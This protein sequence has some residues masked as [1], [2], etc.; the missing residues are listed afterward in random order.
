MPR[1]AIPT[2]LAALAALALGAL[3]PAGTAS[4]AATTC[5]GKAATIVVPTPAEPITDLTETAPVTGTPGDDVIVGTDARDTI[6]GGAGDDTICALGGDDTVRGGAGDDRLFGGLDGVYVADDDFW[7]DVVVP[8]PGDDHVDLGHDPQGEDLWWGDSIYLDRVSFRDATGPVTVDMAAGTATGEGDDTIAPVVLGA[9][10]EGSPHDDVLRGTDLDDQVDAG[11]G[12]DLVEGRGGDDVVE[13]DRLY[14]GMPNPPAAEPGD[15]VVHGGPGDDEISGGHGVDELHGD[16]GRDAVRVEDAEEGTRVLGGPG[17]DGLGSWS[18][19]S[20]GRAT[21]LGGG[22]DDTFSPAIRSADD[23]VVVRG[24]AGADR[25]VPSGS[26]RAAPH[27]SRVEIDA[28]RGTYRMKAGIPVRFSSVTSFGW[29]GSAETRL[30]WWGTRRSEVFRLV[31]QYGPV[32]AYGGGGSDRIAGG[33]GRDLLD[34]GPGRDVLDGD[35]GRDR[36]VRGE[37]L[38]ACELRG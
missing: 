19:L 38:K 33:S 16:G 36:C 25:I 17:R 8:G 7:G 21:F 15:D 1:T 23:E 14:S 20:T 4:A 11:G 35:R 30:T 29:D 13:A 18:F 9:G 34:G 6:D 31:E 12:D 10:I 24:G 2:A 26:L 28:R 22:G 27:G 5:E 32:R 37:R 3:G